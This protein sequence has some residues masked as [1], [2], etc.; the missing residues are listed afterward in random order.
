MPSELL[1]K[2]KLALR[3]SDDVFDEEIQDL[4][5]AALLDLGLSGIDDARLAPQGITELV[6]LAVIQ[7]AKATWGMDN[8]DSEKYWK[9][10]YQ[11]ERD[12]TL[13]GYYSGGSDDALE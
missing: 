6:E 12:L 7:Y 2:V 5:N 10:Y 13:S 8:P 3:V 9:V 1:A 11:L 4:I